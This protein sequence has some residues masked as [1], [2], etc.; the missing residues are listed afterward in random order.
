MTQ[1]SIFSNYCCNWLIRP[2]WF[3]RGRNSYT[4]QS[5][6]LKIHSGN[7]DHSKRC[8][9][10]S[11]CKTN[12]ILA[13]K[14]CDLNGLKHVK[15]E[16]CASSACDHEH[17]SVFA[18]FPSHSCYKCRS[19]K[20]RFNIYSSPGPIEFWIW[21]YSSRNEYFHLKKLYPWYSYVEQ[22]CS[23]TQVCDFLGKQ[24]L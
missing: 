10:C 12:S 2:D 11:H 16:C 18:G 15:S 13:P 9:F 4:H 1:T 3:A 7:R 6:K 14:Q 22:A 19:H 21:V 20:F 23:A 5:H 17:T 24:D 8:S